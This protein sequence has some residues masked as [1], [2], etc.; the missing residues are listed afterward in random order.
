MNVSSDARRSLWGLISVAAQGLVPVVLLDGGSGAG[1][2]SY[3]HRLADA[4][5][6][7]VQVISLDELYPGWDG[8]AEGTRMLEQDLL[9]SAT[10][11]Y[12]RWDWDA[13][14]RGSWQSVDLSLPTIVEGCGALT[15]ATRALATFGIW[16]DADA[17]ERRRRALARDGEAYAPHWERWAAQEQEHWR[18]HRPWELA[19][20]VLRG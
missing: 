19:D 12:W 4:G 9:G 8:L 14:R 16:L 18:A 15:P 10:P 5:P 17:D 13:E 3:A 6:S 2:T 11:G 20:V 7:E 1:K